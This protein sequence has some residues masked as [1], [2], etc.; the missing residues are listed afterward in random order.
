MQIKRD[1]VGGISLLPL[2]LPSLKNL[3]LGLEIIDCSQTDEM[4]LAKCRQL[5]VASFPCL[6]SLT[7]V[8]SALANLKKPTSLD[9]HVI[10]NDSPER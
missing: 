4:S 1:V 5:N 3:Y 2:V 6:G 9:I 7:D 8:L 10:W